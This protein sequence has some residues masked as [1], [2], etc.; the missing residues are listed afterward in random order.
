[1]AGGQTT[2]NGTSCLGSV[3]KVNPATGAYIWQR[4]LTD[5]PVLG[6]VTL[7]KGVAIVAAG[8]DV[9][10]ISTATGQTLATLTDSRGN[11]RY[12]AGAS[13]SNGVIYIGNMDW[14]LYAYGL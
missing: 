9:L 11:S 10:A 8:H 7:V 3:Q 13:V 12:F 4:C 5:G 2:I 6:P 14:N 1:M